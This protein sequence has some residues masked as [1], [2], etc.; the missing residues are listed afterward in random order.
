MVSVLQS[1]D[2]SLTDAMLRNMEAEQERR[3]Q[4]AARHK[5]AEAQR[6][7]GWEAGGW[8]GAALTT[9]LHRSMNLKVQQLVKEQQQCHQQVSR[10]PPEGRAGGRRAGSAEAPCGPPTW[11]GGRLAPFPQLQQAYCELNRRI[12]EHD[13]CERRGVGLAEL[14]LQVGFSPLDLGS[15][16]PGLS[17]S[18][19]HLLGRAPPLP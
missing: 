16:T 7:G 3:A 15:P 18:S 14:T 11:S 5:E 10:L 1:W 6:C 9:P 17:A 2:L 12:A 19:S 13:K 4:E 8:P